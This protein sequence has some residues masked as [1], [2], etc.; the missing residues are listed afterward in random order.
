M[1]QPLGFVHPSHPSYVCKLNKFLYGLKQAPRA[2]YEELYHSLLS[3]GFIPS[4]ANPS[5]FVKADHCLTFILVYVDD[6]IITDTSSIS[7]QALISQLSA[8][9]SQ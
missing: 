7:C 2:W 6:I 5:L 4:K 8:K 3:L 1:Q 9:F